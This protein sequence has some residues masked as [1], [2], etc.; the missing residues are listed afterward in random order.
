MIVTVQYAL[1]V[2]RRLLLVNPVIITN[3]ALH[4]TPS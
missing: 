4:F 2:A 1:L 3:I